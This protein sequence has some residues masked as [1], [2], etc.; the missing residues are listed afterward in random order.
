MTRYFRWRQLRI[1]ELL[2]AV[3]VVLG[4]WIE[5]DSV[6]TFYPTWIYLGDVTVPTFVVLPTVLAIALIGELLV[7]H[8]RSGPELSLAHLIRGGLAIATLLTVVFAVVNLHLAQPGVFF[9]GFLP[10][11]AGVVL[12]VSVLLSQGTSFARRM[13]RSNR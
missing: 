7:V 4:T 2:L 8:G 6:V 11:F 3:G 5:V 1:I 9:A 13:T 10:L 12:A